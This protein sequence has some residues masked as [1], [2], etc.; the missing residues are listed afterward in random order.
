MFVKAEKFNNSV[1]KHH[2]PRA[3]QPRSPRYLV[4]SG[5]YIK[6]IEK[7]IYKTI[8][9]M[10]D[11]VTIFKGLNAETR[12]HHISS[13]WNSFIDPVAVG[14]D[15]KRFDQHV[16]PAMLEWEHSI[17]KLF[18]PG[19]KHFAKIMKWQV[20]NTGVARCAEGKARYTV[21]GCRMSGDMNT[22]LGNCLIMSS[23][24]YAYARKCG[25]RIKLAN[26][27]DD[28]VVFMER[29]DL[30]VFSDNLHNFFSSLGFSMT[31]EDPVYILEDIE[32]CQS[33]PIFDGEKYIM[34]R[35]PRR[36][37]SKDCVAIKPLDNDKIM[38]MWCSAVGQGGMSLTGG[39]PVW[40][41]FY[42]RLVSIIDGAKPLDDITLNT[43]MKLMAKG[44]YRNY[45][46]VDPKTRLSFYLAFKVSPQEQLAREDFYRKVSFQRD[47]DSV[48]FATLPLY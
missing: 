21:D 6:P 4:E 42:A 43:G 3:I 36:A 9:I 14:L 11:S 16:S 22:A 25:I 32:F 27:G 7:K 34:V 46:E 30:N 47:G 15:A 23:M 45:K 35:D 28:C 26:D 40:Q 18:Y 33:H 37:I 31:V 38:K 17:Y 8:N 39:I 10:F 48:R 29:K 44:M 20:K 12:G 13:H 19:D 2:V 41:D 24:V 5:R 1:K